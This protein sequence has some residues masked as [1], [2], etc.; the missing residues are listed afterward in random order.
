[1]RR[2]KLPEVGDLVI[3][4]VSKIFDHGVYV[5]LDE[6]EDLFAYC[7]IS[8]VSHAWVRN[9]R[10]VM[11]IGKKVVGRVLRVREGQIDISIKRV[12]E[13]LKRAKVEE[14]KHYNT[15]LTL[16]EMAAKKLKIDLE[17][18]RSEVEDPCTE[19]Y[20]SFYQAF[21]EAL[22]K[23]EAAFID[24]GVDE[25]WAKELTEIAKRNLTIPRVEIKRD[26]EITC[27]E[28]DGIK[29]IRQALLNA[30][31]ARDEIDAGEE[32]LCMEI[33]TKGAPI[34]RLEISARDYQLAETLAKKAID[35]VH[36]TLKDHKGSVREI[37]ISKK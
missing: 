10:N 3:G 23:G 8:E 5:D 34:Y 7:H 26:L 21:E 20:G 1:M 27:W 22:F 4:T 15:A 29:V 25:K 17:T 11:R 2:R 24:A 16:L 30:L 18:A 28:P 32:E 9:I 35:A 19:Y 6:Y 31:K 12:S 37:E 36:E 14:W 33:Y 13:E